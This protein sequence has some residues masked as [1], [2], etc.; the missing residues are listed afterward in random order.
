MRFGSALAYA[1]GSRALGLV[2]GFAAGLRVLMLRPFLNGSIYYL[3]FEMVVMIF[4]PL[5]KF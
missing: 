1:A 2:R 4:D 3:L 5:K